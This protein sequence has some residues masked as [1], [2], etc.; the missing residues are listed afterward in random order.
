M[1]QLKNF[2]HI[3]SGVYKECQSF[4]QDHSLSEEE[5]QIFTESFL[6]SCKVQSSISIYILKIY[7]FKY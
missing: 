2:Y 7:T 5:I 4:Y 6:E 1:A 3:M